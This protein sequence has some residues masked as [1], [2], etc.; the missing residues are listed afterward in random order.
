MCQKLR[1]SLQCKDTHFILT[2]SLETKV[3]VV[4]ACLGNGKFLQMVGKV[5]G[6]TKST[7][8]IIVKKICEVVSRHLKPIIFMKPTTIRIK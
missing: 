8:S 3:V 6:I 1:E 5:Y 7:T 2:I 4:L